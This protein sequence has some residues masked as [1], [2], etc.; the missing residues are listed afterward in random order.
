MVLDIYNFHHIYCSNFYII[1]IKG[2][3]KGLSLSPTHEV[4]FK[5]RCKNNNIIDIQYMESLDM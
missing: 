3:I 4:L 1:L 5:F 2:T